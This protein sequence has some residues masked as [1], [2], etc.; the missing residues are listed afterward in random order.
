MLRRENERA[1]I[2]TVVHMLMSPVSQTRN[3]ILE[4]ADEAS[5]VASG[6]RREVSKTSSSISH[7]PSSYCWNGAHSQ[8]LPWWSSPC[9]WIWWTGFWCHGIAY[10]T[11]ESYT[12]WLWLTCWELSCSSRVL[13]EVSSGQTQHPPGVLY[14]SPECQRSVHHIQTYWPLYQGTV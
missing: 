8:W 1:L 14:P 4:S 6:S 12:L 5:C 11:S 7:S 13:R 10:N 3:Q 9:V 2:S